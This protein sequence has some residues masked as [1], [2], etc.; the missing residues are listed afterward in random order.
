MDS[1]ELLLTRRSIRKYDDNQVDRDIMKEVIE[2]TKFAPSWKNFQIAR[3]NL[4]DSKRVITEIASNGVNGHM[5]N[6][7]TLANASNLC[8]LSYKKGLSGTS[9]GD[10]LKSTS[11]WEAFDAGI[12]A[13]QFCLSCHTFGIGTVIMGIIDDVEIAKIINLPE[14]EVVGAVIVYGYPLN[15]EKKAPPRKDVN[16]LI[17]FI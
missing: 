4:V 9:E 10:V 1:R 17:R 12:A 5:Y 11:D 8:V 15:K 3:F 16:D 6:A 13:L 14:D 7:K 2:L